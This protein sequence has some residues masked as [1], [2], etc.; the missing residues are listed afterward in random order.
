MGE[1]LKFLLATFLLC[2]SSMN[3]LA[4][5]IDIAGIEDEL[6]SEFITEGKVHVSFH[7]KLEKNQYSLSWKR[8]ER[9]GGPF[10]PFPLTMS[11]G[12]PSL[13]WA[14]EDFLIFERGCGTF[15]WYVKVFSL[16][17]HE[18]HQ[19]P[20]Y[21]RIARP[22]AFDSK[23]NLLAYYHS[24]DVIHIKN[25]VSGFEQ[26]VRTVYA[27]ETSSGLCFTDV[28]FNNDE[29][30]YTWRWNPA[31]EKVSHPLIQELLDL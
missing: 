4:D 18:M 11:C 31:G 8:G 22:L 16:T 19:V 26:A 13:E 30:E 9:Q 24:K 27:C 21:Q 29:L 25:L 14:N 6:Q 10:G 3:L 17:E 12:T 7:Y 28:T 5:C 15:C 2:S 1:L 23:R 20:K